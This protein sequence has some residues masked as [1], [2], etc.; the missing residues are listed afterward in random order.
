M[1]INEHMYNNI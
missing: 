1:L